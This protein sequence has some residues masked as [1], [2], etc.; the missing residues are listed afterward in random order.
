MSSKVSST[1]VATR[2]RRGPYAG[3]AGA[4]GLNDA[5]LVR[6]PT[7]SRQ[8]A[9][10]IQV[11]LD[12]SAEY[13]DRHDAAMDLGAFDSD[14]V[15]SALARIACDASADEGLADAT[16][17]SLADLWCRR[18]RFNETILVSLGPISRRIALGTMK[19]KCQALAASAERLLGVDS[20]QS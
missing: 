18:G 13:G 7:M 9:G 4:D 12:S 15:E 6:V 5:G 11:L 10:L 17:E 19:A 16:G 20:A 1:R 14:A 2:A 3:T 8:A